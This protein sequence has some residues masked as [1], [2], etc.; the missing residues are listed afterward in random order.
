[1]NSAFSE[2]LH[3]S[4][5]I[6]LDAVQPTDH[7]LKAYCVPHTV[8]PSMDS[9]LQTFM[10]LFYRFRCYNFQTESVPLNPLKPHL[11]S[12][13]RD[14]FYGVSFLLILQIFICVSVLFLL[15]KGGIWYFSV[16][17]RVPW[18]QEL[19][20]C[21]LLSGSF[22]YEVTLEGGRPEGGGKG[23][24][25]RGKASGKRGREGRE[26]DGGGGEEARKT[27]S[28]NNLFPQ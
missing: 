7:F 15:F 18:T 10:C 27:S 14:L 5:H 22:V 3:F 28:T 17:N 8:L 1:M 12:P 2:L 6:I 25:R 19:Q 24:K 20:I 26:K 11:R 21:Y 4:F 23:R 13:C 9:V 16:F